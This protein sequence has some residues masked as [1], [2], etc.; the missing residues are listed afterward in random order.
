MAVVTCDTCKFMSPSAVKMKQIT[1]I[2]YSPVRKH[3][4]MG[5]S[6]VLTGEGSWW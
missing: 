6:Y 3:I 5:G 1:G 4:E 2:T